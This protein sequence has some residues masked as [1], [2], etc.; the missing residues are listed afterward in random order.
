MKSFFFSRIFFGGVAFL[1]LLVSFFAVSVEADTDGQ[2]PISSRAAWTYE[3]YKVERLAS[4][5]Q[6]KTLINFGDYVIFVDKNACSGSGNDCILDVTVLQNGMQRT[7]EEV[8]AQV[9]QQDR[10]EK[11][12]G[13]VLALV[14]TDE[15]SNNY[16]LYEYDFESGQRKALLKEEAFFRG[17]SSLEAMISK[18]GT[19]FF[20]QEFDFN[21]TAETYKQ[22]AVFVWDSSGREADTIMTQGMRRHEILEDVWDDLALVK[23]VFESGHEQLWIYDGEHQSATA[24]AGTWTEPHGDIQSAHFLEDGRVD[25]F[26]YFRHYTYNPATDSTPVEQINNLNWYRDINE[27][28]QTAGSYVSWLDSEDTL[29]MS[30]AS[31]THN[32]G[33]AT[34]GDFLSTK[35]AIYYASGANTIR[36][37][38]DTEARMTIPFNVTDTYEEI[39]VG[40][41]VSGAVFYFNTETGKQ[42]TV[43]YGS[44]PVLSDTDHLYWKGQDGNVYEATILLSSQTTISEA[45]VIRESDDS[46]LFLFVNG[47]TYYA[48]GDQKSAI[49]KSWFGENVVI[50]SV[51]ANYL[52]HYINGGQAPYAPGTR[53]KLTGDPKVYLVG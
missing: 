9:L 40:T 50:Q 45:K 28:I 5:L 10:L 36:Y 13:R 26:Q 42:L 41:D 29:H 7:L 23:M 27:S 38:L 49:L 14:P 21:N 15:N 37:D 18:D 43:G 24:I 19:I 33:T 17:V 16:M 53:L 3:G 20:N 32:L 6:E 12:D 46:E 30:T 44:N 39:A 48:L 4:S 51:V 1:L 34:A 31:G 2:T 47:T 11:N 25:F 35:E 8:P 52:D 22:A